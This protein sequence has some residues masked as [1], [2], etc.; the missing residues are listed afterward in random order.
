MNDSDKF[1][2]LFG[3]IFFSIGAV[4]FTVGAAVLFATHIFI[5][6]GIPM[7]IGLIF[8]SIGGGFLLAQIKKKH[9]RQA[10]IRNGTRFVGKIYG[11]V[12]DTSY[13]LNGAFPYN[14]KVHYFD[15]SGTE[16]EALIPTRFTKGTGGYPIGATIDIYVLGTTYSWDKDSVRFEHI[17]GEEELMD[18]LPLD[19]MKINA[20][21]VNCN[22]CGASFSAAKGYVSK[23]PYC[24]SSINC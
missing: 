8:A 21:A 19:P 9:R 23:C 16:R 17:D 12:E 18:D 3:G 10:I 2:Y 20:I 4:L 14:I 1:F 7:L 11:Y 13:T 22:S 24:G 15:Q 5:A 6:G